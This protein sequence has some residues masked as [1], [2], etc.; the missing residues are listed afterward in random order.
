MEIACLPTHHASDL[1]HAQVAE[2][3]NGLEALDRK[4]DILDN[5]ILVFILRYAGMHPIVLVTNFDRPE[6]IE[7]ERAVGSVKVLPQVRTEVHDGLVFA[8]FGAVRC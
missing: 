3:K 7:L 1:Q 6:K 4:A 8:K 5:D 2:A